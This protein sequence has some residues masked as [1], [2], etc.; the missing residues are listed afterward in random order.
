MPLRVIVCSKYISRITL[1]KPSLSDV[2]KNDL[3]LTFFPKSFSL[4]LKMLHG[5]AKFIKNHFFQQLKITEE[6]SVLLGE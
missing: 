6:F 4:L 5:Q 2:K 1:T 3:F